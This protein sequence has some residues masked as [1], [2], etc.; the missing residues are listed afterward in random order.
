ML[1]ERGEIP[2]SVDVLLG[3]SADAFGHPSVSTLMKCSAGQCY[4]LAVNGTMKP[5]RVRFAGL[6]SNAAMVEVLWEHRRVRIAD[7]GF[8][9][10]FAPFGVHVYRWPEPCAAL[11]K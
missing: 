5:V 1:L 6:G 11:C 10:T 8:E 7:G 9:E 3:P 2:V 4:L